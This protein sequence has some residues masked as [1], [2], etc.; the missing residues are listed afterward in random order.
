M[1]PGN[2]HIVTSSPRSRLWFLL[3]AVVLCAPADRLFA[4]EDASPPAPSPPAVEA[5]PQGLR[6]LINA[7]G[8]I[9]WVIIGLSVAAV[10]LIV[11]HVISIRRGTLLPLPL[12]EEAHQLINQGRFADA[13]QLARNSS[14][15]LGH[16][17]AAGLAE[18]TVGYKAAE[19]AMEDASVEQSAR[20]FR[21]IEY[22]SVI[23]TIAPMLGLLGTVLGM[24]EAFD[25]FKS[26]ANPQ[27]SQFA[28][29][30]SRALVTTA[31]G[32]IVAVPALAG[33]AIFRNRIDGL[34]AEAT[35]LAEHLFADFKRRTM[36]K[37]KTQ[38]PAKKGTAG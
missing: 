30:I 20:L 8:T 24:I 12:A 37:R 23:G 36:A 28:P 16:V 38:P 10:A 11:E 6:D 26:Q 7:G 17:L 5:A 21:K 3:L 35:L 32:L 2:P 31:M 1:Y 34:V 33:Y 18:V 22:L 9:G 4:Q 15:F 14:S 13:E 29:G 25:Q 19:K 27:V